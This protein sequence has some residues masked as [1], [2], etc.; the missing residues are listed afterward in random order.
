MP[1]V[2]SRLKSNVFMN[3]ERTRG[4]SDRKAPQS[5]AKRFHQRRFRALDWSA[6]MLVPRWIRADK[7]AAR[8][9][10]TRLVRTQVRSAG[11]RFVVNGRSHVTANN[12][13]GTNVDFNGRKV[14]GSGNV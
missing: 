5:A 14:H 3:R 13:L 8:W 1:F 4:S 10:W 2:P 11:P 6:H 9:F 7:D 12:V